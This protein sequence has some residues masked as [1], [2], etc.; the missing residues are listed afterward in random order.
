MS[1]FDGLAQSDIAGELGCMC[2]EVHPRAGSICKGCRAREVGRNCWEMQISPC[3]DRPRD[4]CKTCLVYA[5]AMR[6]LSS[7]ELVCIVL[8]GGTIIDGEVSVRH[9]QRVSDVFNDPETEYVAVTNARVN[10]STA[11]GRPADERGIVLVSK[12]AAVLITPLGEAG[13]QA[14]GDRPSC[15]Q[16]GA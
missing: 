13:A 11:S 12:R 16:S 8:E 7:R 15:A 9:N 1:Q 14:E 10:Y 6:G 2:T 5:N 4:A 3:C